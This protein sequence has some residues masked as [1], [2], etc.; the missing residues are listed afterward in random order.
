MRLRQSS[1]SSEAIIL[2]QED[3]VAMEGDETFQLRLVAQ[4]TLGGNEFVAD[5]LSLTIVDDTSTQPACA[6]AS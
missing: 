1:P 2:A 6:P 3:R 4:N 5:P